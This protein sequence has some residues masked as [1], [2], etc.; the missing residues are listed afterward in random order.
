MFA[1]IHEAPADF[2]TATELADRVLISEVDWLDETMLDHQRSWVGQEPDGSRLSWKSLPARAREAGIR[3]RGHFDGR[4]GMPDAQAARRAIAYVLQRFDQA[5]AVLLYPRSGRSAGAP[6][7]TGA[8]QGRVR[9]AR[10]HC[11]RTGRG[12]TGMLASERLHAGKRRGAEWVAAVRHDL[13][14]DPCLRPHEL[15]A[16]KDQQAKRSA[17]RVLAVLT[18][19]SLERQQKCWRETEL[20]MLEQRGDANGLRDYLA[21]VKEKLIPLITGDQENLEDCNDHQPQG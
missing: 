6:R 9:E 4:P 13:G 11:R 21:E 18:E 5:Q 2:T 16:C 17:K 10:D 19:G 14:F 8:G 7:R 20:S 15:T 3:V 12:R 1:V